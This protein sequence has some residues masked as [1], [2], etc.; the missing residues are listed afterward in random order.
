MFYELYYE[1]LVNDREG[2]ILLSCSPGCCRGYS[3]RH[4]N[5]NYL[6]RILRDLPRARHH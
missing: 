2:A 5:Y 3:M 1:M 4:Y 6:Y